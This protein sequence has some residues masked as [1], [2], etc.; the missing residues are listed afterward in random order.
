MDHAK[1]GMNTEQISHRTTGSN[2][3]G[4]T[5]CNQLLPPFCMQRTIILEAI[6]QIY[7]WIKE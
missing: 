4:L 6:F 2:V 5:K 7:E 1:S 3:P